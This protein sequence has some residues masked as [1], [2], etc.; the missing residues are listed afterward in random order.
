M[1]N[2]V[3]LASNA[4]ILGAA[5]S[6]G[7]EPKRAANQ[8][9][10]QRI[11]LVE[12]VPAGTAPRNRAGAAAVETPAPGSPETAPT[13]TP[14]SAVPAAAGA[15]VDGVAAI[16]A[17]G[18][19][20]RI[21][22]QCVE[23]GNFNEADAAR[24][25]VLAAP[26]APGDRLARR[27]V[28]EVERYIVY[29]PPLADRDAVER[30]SAELR[31]LGVTDFFIFNDNS[32]L[33]N[34]ISLGLFKTAESADQHLATLLRRGVRS[35]KIAAR[36]GAGSKTVFQLRGLDAQGEAAFTR[37][38]ASFPRQETRSCSPA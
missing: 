31:R 32:D 1:A 22:L 21:A 16:D 6:E 19:Q 23:I 4:G 13:A 34:G 17:A 25:A 14:A 5:S 35:A 2:L 36:V 38:Q 11:V 12:P 3:L 15:T 27:S 26:L 9:N 18:A 30:K 20:T 37:I 33:R 10:A 24:F 29:I 8:L 7:H 28:Q